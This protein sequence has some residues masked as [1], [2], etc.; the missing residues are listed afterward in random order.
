MRR[1]R[2]AML[3]TLVLAS[4]L[5][6]ARAQDLAADQPRAAFD[7]FISAFN[8]LDWETFRRCFADSA[9]LFNPDIPD[10]IS[11]DRLDGRKDI[12]RSFRAVFD[13]A[14]KAN[15]H[16]PNIH[17]ESVRVQQFND[18]AIITFA[19][20]RPQHSVGRRTIVLNKQGGS[21]LIVHI[22]ASNIT[23]K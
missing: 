21:W 8:A 20:R 16:G 6:G 10:V 9:S 7:H 3:A 5:G 2:I 11:L 1:P 13:S 14:V 19:F 17:P 4:V 22:H 12:E 23:P 15:T 18:T